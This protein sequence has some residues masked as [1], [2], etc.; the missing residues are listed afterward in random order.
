MAWTITRTRDVTS[1]AVVHLKCVADAATQVVETG[2]K[3]VVHYTFAP[4]SMTTIVGLN[5]AANSNASGVQS[6]G[7]LG[8]SGFNI[9]DVFY[10]SVYGQ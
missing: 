1:K 3:N 8:C 9:G 2:L 6:Y 5:I 10:I 7:V 4:S